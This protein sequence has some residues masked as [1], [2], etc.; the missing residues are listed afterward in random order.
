MIW[1]KDIGDYKGMVAMLKGEAYH[2]SRQKRLLDVSVALGL[3]PLSGAA[4]IAARHMFAEH[5]DDIFFHQTR[6]GQNNTS[7]EMIKLRTLDDNGNALGKVALMYRKFGLDEVVQYR[8]ILSGA[9]SVVGHRPT[10]SEE[11]ETEYEIVGHDYS[12]AQI[13]DTHKRVVMSQRPGCISSYV[14]DA[15]CGKINLDD[16]GAIEHRLTT[17]IEDAES[18]SLVGDLRLIY[19]LAGSVATRQMVTSS[20]RPL[21]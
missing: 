1:Q 20:T 13:V 17:E 3:A 14:I 11:R 10:P 2:N 19:R 8:H 12:G 4:S 7:F 15:H 6:V 21:A 16:P 5:N 18:S 9:M